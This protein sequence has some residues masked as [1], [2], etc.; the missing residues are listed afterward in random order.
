[1]FQRYDVTLAL[2][3]V[4]A[5]AAMAAARRV[6][7]LE[8]RRVAHGYLRV[9]AAL[10]ALRVGSF[11]IPWGLGVDAPAV[12]D[13]ANAV[14]T[15]AGDA[16]LGALFGI[17]AVDARRGG[18]GSLLR[19]PELRFALCLVIG[20]QFTVTGIAKL[21]GLDFMQAFFA[22]SGYSKQFLYFLIMAEVLAGAALLLPWRGI[23]VAAIAGLAVDMAGAIWT[24]VH[25]GD[26]IGDSFAA[27]RTVVWL[28]PLALL[29]VDRR[30]VVA[31][32]AAS[33]AAAVIGSA[34]LR[35]PAPAPDGFGYFL[36]AWQCTGTFAN[37]KPIEAELRADMALDGSWLVIHHDDRPPNH[38]HALVEWY[39]GPSGWVASVQDASGGLRSFRSTGWEGAQLVWNRSDTAIADQRFIYRR[40]DAGRFEMTYTAIKRD[41][42]QQVDTLTCTR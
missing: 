2:I 29:Y 23:V 27:I 13:I 16:M 15:V 36:G 5:I 4:G 1:M 7:A 21:Y 24:H 35:Q 32:A 26:P 38:Y 42:W 6:A 33:V 14:G 11:V 39:R 40:I 19:A 9:A 41:G 34:Q 37:G 8:S 12:F 25:N 10:V 30:W 31:G 28:V 22:Q 20:A 17:A 3:L 18:F